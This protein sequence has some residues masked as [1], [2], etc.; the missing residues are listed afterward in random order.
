MTPCSVVVGFWRALLPPSSGW[1]DWRW[2][3]AS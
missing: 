2:E 1:S 3:K